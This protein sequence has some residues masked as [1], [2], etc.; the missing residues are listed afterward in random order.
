MSTIRSHALPQL[1]SV[2]GLACLIVLISHYSVLFPDVRD[3]LL[4]TPFA[5]LFSAATAVSFFFSLSGFVLGLALITNKGGGYTN[6]FV[7]RL[8][9]IYLPYV[10]S[11]C[12][13][14]FCF[15]A[16]K[17]NLKIDL[18]PWF[19][20]IWPLNLDKTAILNHF[21][22]LGKYDSGVLN[23]VYWSLVIELRI[24]IILPLI[25]VLIMKNEK[26]A[27]W[28][29]LVCLGLGLLSKSALGHDLL[30]DTF[31]YLP[32]FIFGILAAKYFFYQSWSV[33]KRNYLITCVLILFTEPLLSIVGIRSQS[34]NSLLTGLFSAFVI[35][36]LANHPPRQLIRTS[37]VYLGRISFSIYLTHS[38]VLISLIYLLYGIL[39]NIF[40]LLTSLFLTLVISILCYRFIE[41]PS[42]LLGKT[43]AYAI[44]NYSVNSKRDVS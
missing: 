39:P 29:I 35:L 5:F 26:H 9:R 20:Q 42:I 44:K 27:V 1:D 32:N 43:L 12:L 33:S 4:H 30:L 17:N 23:P 16:F 19:A 41:A 25:F 28:I 7:R 14:L 24:S 34:V 10:F 18:G 38:T 21:L 36:Y 31:I 15:W 8:S 22:F 13:S 37:F 40:I 11:L 6:F 2:R 3:F